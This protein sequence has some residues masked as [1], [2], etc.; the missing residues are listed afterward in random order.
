[1]S[2]GSIIVNVGHSHLMKAQDGG[3]VKT[4]LPRR[5]TGHAEIR[6][7]YAAKNPALN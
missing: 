5:A 2:K 3:C 6:S 1:M 4:P 7:L